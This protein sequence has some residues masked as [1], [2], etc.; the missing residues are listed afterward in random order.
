MTHSDSDSLNPEALKN[1]MSDIWFPKL[2]VV[3]ERDLQSGLFSNSILFLSFARLCCASNGTLYNSLASSQFIMW[4]DVASWLSQQVS[5]PVTGVL[6]SRELLSL[7]KRCNLGPYLVLEQSPSDH[8][9]IDGRFDWYRRWPRSTGPEEGTQ[10]NRACLLSLVQ[11]EAAGQCWVRVQVPE[12]GARGPSQPWHDD[13]RESKRHICLHEW[14]FE[15]GRCCQG[16]IASRHPWNASCHWWLCCTAPSTSDK[17]TVETSGTACWQSGTGFI[18]G[19]QVLPWWLGDVAWMLGIIH[20]AGGV[21]FQAKHCRP[22]CVLIPW[23]QTSRCLGSPG[24]AG[25]CGRILSTDAQRQRH[26]SG[27]HQGAIEGDGGMSCWGFTGRQEHQ[28]GI[29]LGGHSH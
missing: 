16:S 4:S 5:S 21:P 1:C 10:L 7:S 6:G 20:A 25:V 27:K 24:W 3:K 28:V 22:K 9:A 8:Q 17:G 26:D 13:V 15:V 18:H 12:L 19:G 14:G 23:L 29:R 2:R 11:F